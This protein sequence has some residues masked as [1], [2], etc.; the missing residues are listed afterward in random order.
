MRVVRYVVRTR[1]HSW[2]LKGFAEPENESDLF[3]LAFRRKFVRDLRE[4][5]RGRE[6]R[7]VSDGHGHIPNVP[8]PP[9]A[10]D[11]GGGFAQLLL[12]VV[13]SSPCR[14]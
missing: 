8:H 10:K 5:R 6:V 9:R 3:S 12:S 2:L 1:T 13:R 11:E 4:V 7:V 14:T